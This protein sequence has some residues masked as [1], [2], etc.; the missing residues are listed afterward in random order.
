MLTLPIDHPRD[1]PKGATLRPVISTL[2]GFL[3]VKPKRSS[4]RLSPLF[5]NGYKYDTPQ[6]HNLHLCRNVLL[7]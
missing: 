2:V 5:S 4:F 7:H 6:E 3:R 1:D